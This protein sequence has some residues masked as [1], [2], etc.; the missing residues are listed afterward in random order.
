MLA[1]PMDFTPGVVSLKGR[2]GQAIQNTLARQL[3]DYVVL[4]SPIHMAADLPEHYEQHMDAFQ[5]IRDVPTDWQDTRVLNG[6]VGDYATIVRKDRNSEDWY[7]GSVTDEN[8]RTL[9]V[10]LSFLDKNRTYVAQIYRDG[11]DA[12]WK[13][14]PFAFVSE[15]REVKRGDTLALKLASG[16]GAAIRFAPK[17]Q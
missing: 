5:F 16:G 6:E 12:D 11:D 10:P 8:G 15:T 17:V 7:L 1:G 9:E 13:T 2:G 3:A 14:N 4:Y